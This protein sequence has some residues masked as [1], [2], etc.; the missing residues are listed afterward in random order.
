MTPSNKFYNIG[1]A[2]IAQ[3][4]CLH[5]LSCCPGFNS[6]AHHL[7]F[8]QLLSNLCHICPYDVRKERKESKRGRVW[9]IFLKKSFKTLIPVSPNKEGHYLRSK[10]KIVSKT[11]PTNWIILNPPSLRSFSK[12]NY[13]CSR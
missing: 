13:G 1:G 8:Y 2:A 11:V 10:Q 7:S 9:P 12:P 6:Q 4:F 5:L 3:W